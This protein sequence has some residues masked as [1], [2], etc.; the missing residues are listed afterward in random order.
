M[1]N[2][3]K[4]KGKKDNKHNYGEIARI[5]RL[6]K[7]TTPIP[8]SKVLKP[9]P[10]TKED[11]V[12]VAKK[13]KEWVI[14]RGYKGYKS[15]AEYD[16]ATPESRTRIDIIF[17]Q[18]DEGKRV[19]QDIN[20]EY[21]NSLAPTTN[22]IRTPGK[23]NDQV[24]KCMKEKWNDYEVEYYHSF[25]NLYNKRMLYDAQRAILTQDPTTK[26]SKYNYLTNGTHYKGVSQE[27]RPSKSR[28]NE[29]ANEIKREIYRSTQDLTN[30]YTLVDV[31]PDY[32]ES[33]LFSEHP[34]N[35]MKEEGLVD[36]GIMYS[37]ARNEGVQPAI[38]VLASTYSEEADLSTPHLVDLNVIRFVTSIAKITS[39]ARR[40]NNDI[41][42]QRR[43]QKYSLKDLEKLN[44]VS[45]SLPSYAT[46]YVRE[47]LT[48]SSPKRKAISVHQGVIKV[49]NQLKKA[50]GQP[51]NCS[52]ISLE[53][54][55]SHYG[56][57]FAALFAKYNRRVKNGK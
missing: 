7:A 42:K 52:K 9:E 32:V 23:Y 35:N 10:I 5:C 51:R 2:K 3:N 22:N 12:R 40:Y 57:L 44:R 53:M 21:Y 16:N 36:V 47:L 26:D 33:L 20:I 28:L 1:D 56:L 18:G 45:E 55:F 13:F 46:T 17:L 4:G 6:R 25:N 27:K 29:M 34:D 15:K 30:N 19:K 37:L 38:Q 43:K 31:T 41:Q 11:E 50:L 8:V 49:G 39:E 24:D 14:S 54:L 48:P